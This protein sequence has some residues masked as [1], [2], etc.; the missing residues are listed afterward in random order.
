MSDPSA[1][2]DTPISA[3]S[4]PVT[5][6]KRRPGKNAI[7]KKPATPPPESSSDSDFSGEDSEKRPIKRRKRVAVAASSADQQVVKKDLLAPSYVAAEGS[8]ELKNED[9]ATKIS[10]LEAEDEGAQRRAALARGD[11]DALD[12]VYKGKAG[13]TNFLPPKPATNSSAEPPKPATRGP[14]KAPANIRTITVTDYAPDVCKDY[15]QTGFCGFG[16]NCKFLHA[17]EDYAQGWQLDREWEIQKVAGGAVKAGLIRSHI[18]TLANANDPLRSD[19]TREEREEERIIKEV[20]FKCV[21]CKGDYKNPIVTKCQHYFCEKCAINRY[22]GRSGKKRNPSCAICGGRTDGV[23]NPAKTLGKML[24]KKK[25]REEA[26]KKE[27]EEKK[28][29]EEEARKVVRGGW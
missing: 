25:E 1:P 7:R 28:K 16:D 5:F 6:F 2:I 10:A 12:G 22:S 17:R 14:I 9:D 20:P 13:Y 27:E 19:S 18:K 15:K 4:A 26:A 8:R 23:F 21:I 11:A 29:L 24:E 3:P